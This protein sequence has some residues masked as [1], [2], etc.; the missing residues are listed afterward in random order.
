[1][2]AMHQHQTVF[3]NLKRLEDG[4]QCASETSELPSRRDDAEK[5]ARDLLTRQDLYLNED[6]IL[7]HSEPRQQKC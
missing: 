3:S 6:S 7:C 2:I 4:G 5:F 1:M